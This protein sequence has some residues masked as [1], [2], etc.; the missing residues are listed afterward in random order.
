[1]GKFR[2]NTTEPSRLQRRIKDEMDES[3]GVG[4]SDGV[5]MTLYQRKKVILKSTKRMQVEKFAA[6]PNKNCCRVSYEKAK[7]SSPAK[8]K[9]V[10][11]T[12]KVVKDAEKKLH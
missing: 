9:E 12:T 10:P 3:E 2:S 1:M 4:V 6:K 5:A 8:V 11:S 7:Q